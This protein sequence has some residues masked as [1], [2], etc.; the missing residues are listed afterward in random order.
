[1]KNDSKISPNMIGFTLVELLVV[2][3]VIGILIS[4]LLPAVQAARAAAR[5]MQC[6]NNLKQIG[7]ACHNFADSHQESFPIGGRNHDYSPLSWT[8]YLLPFLEQTARMSL[9]SLHYVVPTETSGTGGY[10]YDSEDTTV[11]GGSYR[12]KQNVRAWQ[13]SLPAYSCPSNLSETFKTTLYGGLEWKKVSYLA[14]FGSTGIADYRITNADRTYSWATNYS[15]DASTGG[16]PDDKQDCHGA[17]FGFVI[18]YSKP[19]EQIN[20]SGFGEIPIAAATDGLSN[21]ALFSE[22]IT[23]ES[24]ASWTTQYS[25][26]RGFAHDPRASYFTTY[27]EPNTTIPDELAVAA[28]CHRPGQ[29][30]TNACPCVTHWGPVYRSSARSL[31]TGGVNTV[32]GDGHVVFVSDTINRNVWRA[33]GDAADG[34]AL[35][36][37]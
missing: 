33:L 21:T 30:Y 4:L 34:I 8:P 37:P 18:A 14:C 16:D 24:D 12:R 26:A 3:A 11:Y 28:Q 5:R 19:Y 7:L 23:T 10:V 32:L 35:S 17:L 13:E 15:P 9:L 27:Y 22:T 20:A 25:D 29:P 2:I 31:H 36:L 1:M 6:A